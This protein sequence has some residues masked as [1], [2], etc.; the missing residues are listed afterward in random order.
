MEITPKL[1]AEW[2]RIDRQ[3]KIRAERRRR[4]FGEVRGIFV[5]LL[6]AA[7]F[8]FALNHYTEIKSLAA[9]KL[10]AA[11]TK[12]NHANRLRQGAINYQNQVDQIAQ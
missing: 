8:V 1:V 12:A 6:L 3:R 2:I 10:D 5:F 11:I 9:T 7:I 4:F